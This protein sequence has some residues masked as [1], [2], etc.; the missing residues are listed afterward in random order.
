LRLPHERHRTASQTQ[1]QRKNEQELQQHDKR[2][3]A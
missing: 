2:D 3:H 1:N